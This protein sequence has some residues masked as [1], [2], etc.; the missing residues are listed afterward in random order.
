MAELVTGVVGET[1]EYSG[2]FSM[3]EVFRIIDTFFRQRGFD[4][5]LIFDEQY[6][7]PNGRYIHVKMQPYKKWDD[8][9]RTQLRL[10]IYGKNLIDVEK[11]VEGTKIKTNQGTLLIVFDSLIQTDYRNRWDTPAFY[12]VMRTI[13]EKYILGARSKRY[14]DQARYVIQELRANL[15][16]YLNTNKSLY[17]SQ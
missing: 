14:E 10:W 8:Y 3:K 9:V 6:E 12:F 7:T 15:S 1:L 11:E 13:M 16:S 4:K 5:K 17:G 2:L